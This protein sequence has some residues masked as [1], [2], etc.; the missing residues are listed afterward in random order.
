LPFRATPRQNEHCW[1]I[2]RFQKEF[3]VKIVEKYLASE[4]N[5]NIKIFWRKM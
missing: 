3:E 5:T 2:S 1:G 4:I